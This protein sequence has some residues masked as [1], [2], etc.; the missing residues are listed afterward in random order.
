MLGVRLGA[1]HGRTIGPMADVLLL[2]LGGTLVDDSQ[3]FPHV[4]AALGALVRFQGSSEQPLQLALVSDFAPPDPP[5]PAG[6]KA[7]FSEYLRLLDGFGLRR[8]FQ[9]AGRHVT[10][11]THAG[12]SKPDRRLYELALQRLGTGAALSDCVSITEDAGHAVACRALGMTALRFGT[13][14]TDWSEAPLLVRRLT[15]PTSAANTA[16]A[17]GV[18]LSA[19]HGRKLAGLDGPPTAAGVDVRLRPPG[20]TS[21]SVTFDDAG[22]VAALDWD[23]GSEAAV[24][25][26][27]LR[28]HGQLAPSEEGP[29]PPGAT[30]RVERDDRGEPV[31][32]RGRFSAL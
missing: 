2:D 1:A 10:L 27:S 32:R 20:A 18:W 17:L 16:L 7:R 13:D 30:H 3:P 28:E 14:L 8:F 21:A 15:D 29:L 19:H 26:R 9:P 12:V 22:R 23:G 5:T 11:S 25:H 4:K 6:V 24:F 31:V